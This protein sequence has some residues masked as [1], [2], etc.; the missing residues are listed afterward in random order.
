LNPREN[1]ELVSELV[2]FVDYTPP[3]TAP[4]DTPQV[5]VADANGDLLGNMLN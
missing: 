3:E 1:E 4:D 5:A 2:A